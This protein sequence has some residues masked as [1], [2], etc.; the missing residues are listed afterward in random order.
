MKGDRTRSTK[1]SITS[2][3]EKGQAPEVSYLKYKFYG[4]AKTGQK[5]LGRERK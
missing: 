2:F 4:I 3:I 5:K 1:G